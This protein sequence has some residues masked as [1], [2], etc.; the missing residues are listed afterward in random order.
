MHAAYRAHLVEQGL[1]SD[2]I[3]KL[4][5]VL[6]DGREPQEVE[7]WNRVLTAEDPRFNTD[8]NAYLVRMVEGNMPERRCHE[9]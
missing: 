5:Q 2:E 1:G 4:I 6:Q 9:Q 8:P 3:E 7:M